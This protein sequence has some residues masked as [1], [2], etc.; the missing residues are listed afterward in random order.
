MVTWRSIRP[1]GISWIRPP[2]KLSSKTRG[3]A[4]KSGPRITCFQT[5]SLRNTSYYQCVT[6]PSS[7]LFNRPIIVQ[8]LASYFIQREPFVETAKKTRKTEPRKKHKLKRKYNSINVIK[9]MFADRLAEKTNAIVINEKL[10]YPMHASKRAPKQ[11]EDKLNEKEQLKV[12]KT[13]EDWNSGKIKS[14]SAKHL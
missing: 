10:E 5:C 13:L 2:V 3:L 9:V 14:E 6:Y 12:A 11:V 1:D 8:A 4:S 7:A